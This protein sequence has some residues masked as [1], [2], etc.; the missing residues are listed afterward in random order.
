MNWTV[1]VAQAAAKSLAKFPAK[2]QVRIATALSG[3]AT[4]P[5]SGDVVKLEGEQLRWRRR[6]GSYRIF[7]SVDSNS[8]IVAISAALPPPISREA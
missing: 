8:R 3:M 7:F 2:D 5:F 1:I 4:D 6:V